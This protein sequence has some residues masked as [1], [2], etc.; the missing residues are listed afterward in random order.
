M[1]VDALGEVVVH[2]ERR[3]RAT[4]W[5][6]WYSW[7]GSESLP[8]GPVPLMPNRLWSLVASALWPQPDSSMAWAMVTAAGTPYACAGRR[9][10]P[11]ATALMKA[12]CR[13]PAAPRWAGAWCCWLSAGAAPATP[14]E[15]AGPGRQARDGR[16][17]RGRAQ[18][19]LRPARPGACRCGG[20]PAGSAHP[21]AAGRRRG[22][23]LH[24]WRRA[25]RPPAGC[26]CAAAGPAAAPPARACAWLRPR[27]APGAWSAGRAAVPGMPGMA[28]RRLDRAGR[29]AALAAAPADCPGLRPAAVA[30]GR[31]LGWPGRSRGWRPGRRPPLRRPGCRRPGWPWPAGGAPDVAA[32]AVLSAPGDPLLTNP[33]TPW[34]A[35]GAAYSCALT[36]KLGSESPPIVYR[37][38][39]AY[40]VT[41]STWPSNSTQSPGWGW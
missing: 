34:A 15:L 23:H 25:A 5:P 27:G 37:T 4:H 21:D 11:G 10:R 28:A 14:A 8:A 32:A 2:A 18:R 39:C 6:F 13:T 24:R 9:S 41:T 26:R 19:P 22:R 1:V 31:L 3:G 33:T 29:A 17:A 35:S 38:P 7:V 40:S 30:P 20:D 36:E 12:C 16:T